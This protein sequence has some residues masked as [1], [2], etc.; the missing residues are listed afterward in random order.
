MFDLALLI[1][2]NEIFVDIEYP[3]R[4]RYAKLRPSVMLASLVAVSALVVCMYRSVIR[5]M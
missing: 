2:C 1:V 4:A 3:Q 5:V